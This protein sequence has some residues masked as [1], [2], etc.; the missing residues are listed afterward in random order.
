M[1]ETL[2]KERNEHATEKS[3]QDK[4]MEE[5]MTQVKGMIDELT[6]AERLIVEKRLTSFRSC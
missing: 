2:Q 1:I 4:W 5:I 3:G 6:Q